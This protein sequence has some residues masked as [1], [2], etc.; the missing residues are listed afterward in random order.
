[1]SDE[2]DKVVSLEAFK[3]AREFGEDELAR[4]LGRVTQFRFV[5]RPEDRVGTSENEVLFVLEGEGLAF[6][7]SDARALGIALI[8]AAAFVELQQ[9]GVI[10]TPD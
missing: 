4:I 7:V 8:E 2:E 1:M 5:T 10:A 6:S 3:Q 9:K